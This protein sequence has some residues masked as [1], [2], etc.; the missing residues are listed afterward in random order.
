M[1]V[2]LKI[3]RLLAILLLALLGCAGPAAQP[4]GHGTLDRVARGM[5]QIVTP[6]QGP[7]LPL[8]VRGS[9]F[10]VDVDERGRALVYTALHVAGDGRVVAVRSLAMASDAVPVFEGRIVGADAGRDLVLIEVCCAAFEPMEFAGKVGVGDS[11]TALGTWATMY[12]FERLLEEKGGVR[13][14]DFVYSNRYVVFP[15]A[16]QAVLPDGLLTEPDFRYPHK[17]IV[18]SVETV[19]GFSGGPLLAADGRVAGMSIWSFGDGRTLFAH[20]DE[21]EKALAELRDKTKFWSH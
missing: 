17:A 8:L 3:V 4:E 2:V 14:E 18:A 11:V 16:V 19:P 7:H 5:V 13:P 21:L 10:V 20:K 12:E 15:G 9:G 6:D 1:T